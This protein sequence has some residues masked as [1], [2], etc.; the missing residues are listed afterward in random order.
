VPSVGPSTRAVVD[1]VTAL[2]SSLGLAV[3]EPGE[4]MSMYHWETEQEDFLLLSGEAL[5]IVEGESDPCGS[6]ISCAAQ[7]GRST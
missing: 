2:L 3:L 1:S 5:A 7:P 6:G 4:P